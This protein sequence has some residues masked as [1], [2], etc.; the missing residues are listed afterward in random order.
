MIKWIKSIFTKTRNF[1]QLTIDEVLSTGAEIK[2]LESVAFLLLDEEKKK[3]ET[4]IEI[5]KVA[6]AELTALYNEVAKRHNIKL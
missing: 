6:C 5:M 2:K 3:I 4:I 1:Y